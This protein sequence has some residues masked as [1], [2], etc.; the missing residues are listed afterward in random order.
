MNIKGRNNKNKL[1]EL[2]SEDTSNISHN[3]EISNN[4]EV[5]I[6]IRKT[7]PSH[8]AALRDLGIM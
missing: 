7:W 1:N 4:K 5:E 2:S 3:K 6:L 8:H